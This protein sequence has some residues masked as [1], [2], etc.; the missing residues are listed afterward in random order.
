MK[1]IRKI[2]IILLM[3]SLL[4]LPAIAESAE[5]E[6]SEYG[7]F[8]YMAQH[9]LGYSE[10]T[11][12]RLRLIPL[13]GYNDADHVCTFNYQD[14]A[15]NGLVQVTFS[16]MED[17]SIGMALTIDSYLRMQMEA[18]RQEEENDQDCLLRLAARYF[19]ALEEAG[20]YDFI[21]YETALNSEEVVAA[22]IGPYRQISLVRVYPTFL[23]HPL[24]GHVVEVRMD[25]D[26]RVI[27][28]VVVYPL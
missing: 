3:F 19:P 5:Q 4:T 10:T 1:K 2:V 24:A 18:A 13:E 20:T 7:E 23:E 26:T 25:L 15:D 8:R 14:D 17:G 27:N 16:T 21:A 12:A 9:V 28:S 22:G 11:L 6:P